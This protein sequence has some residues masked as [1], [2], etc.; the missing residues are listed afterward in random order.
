MNAQNFK[1]V[2]TAQRPKKE[3]NEKS[4]RVST[5]TMTKSENRMVEKVEKTA[6]FK[7]G[8]SKAAKTIKVSATGSGNK[9]QLRINRSLLTGMKPN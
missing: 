7:D 4:V 9:L 3:H 5:I 2:P 1:L 8:P 6:E